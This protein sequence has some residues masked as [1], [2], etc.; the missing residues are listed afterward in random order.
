MEVFKE[1]L[2]EL[3]LKGKVGTATE[4][5]LTQSA[6]ELHQRKK[7]SLS[8]STKMLTLKSRVAWYV[9]HGTWSIVYDRH[10]HAEL[11]ELR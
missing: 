10:L 5:R 6:S 2:H 11:D 4:S 7:H 8:T 9:A 1:C 3:K